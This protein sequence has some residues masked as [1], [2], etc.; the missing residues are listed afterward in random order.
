MQYVLPV[1]VNLGVFSLGVG[2]SKYFFNLLG[3]TVRL[4]PT[5]VNTCNY[6]QHVVILIYM[7]IKKYKVVIQN[8]KK[9]I[10][11]KSLYQKFSKC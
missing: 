8:N 7:V 6:R 3:H 1:S 4:E 2:T 11:Y 10:T 5:S 9:F